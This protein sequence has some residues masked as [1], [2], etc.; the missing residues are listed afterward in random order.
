M[1]ALQLRGVAFKRRRVARD[2]SAGDI[3]TLLRV[4]RKNVVAFE[5]GVIMQMPRDAESKIASLNSKWTAEELSM[6]IRRR[7]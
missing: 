7:A 2:L 3:A 6:P 5:T 1:E 4:P